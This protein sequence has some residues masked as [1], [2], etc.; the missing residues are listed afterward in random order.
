MMTMMITEMM[1]MMTPIITDHSPDDVITQM[2]T[3]MTLMIT[4]DLR[5]LSDH[6]IVIFV[7]SCV[8]SQASCFLS[9]I[10]FD[11]KLFLY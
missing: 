10:T 8:E 7:Q 11:L 4:N 6:S 2:M 3:M 9:K 1:T 5:A